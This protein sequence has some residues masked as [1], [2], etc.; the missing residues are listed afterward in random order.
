MSFGS[1]KGAGVYYSLPYLTLSWEEAGRVQALACH[2]IVL[3]HISQG[4]EALGPF[5]GHWVMEGPRE[6]VRSPLVP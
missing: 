1:L 5:R 2:L 3:N 6:K 4:A